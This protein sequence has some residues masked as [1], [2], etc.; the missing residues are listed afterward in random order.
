MIAT[1]T[2]KTHRFMSCI[3]VA[4]SLFMPLKPN[5][6]TNFNNAPEDRNVAIECNCDFCNEIT[7]NSS[8]SSF[9]FNEKGNN[10]EQQAHRAGATAAKKKRT[11]IIYVAADNDLSI[12][13]A[14]NIKQMAAVGS[15]EHINVLVHLDIR[16]IGNKKITRRYFIEKETIWHVNAQDS[17]SQSMDSGNPATLIS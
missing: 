7:A 17:F 13:A 6:A 3:L 2:L 9:V 4:L 1:R 14:R 12:F 8:L 16:I 15:N 11:I 5:S 10:I